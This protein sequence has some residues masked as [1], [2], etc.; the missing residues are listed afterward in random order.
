MKIAI[1]GC[2]VA[3]PTLAYWLSRA[4][5][6][7]VLIEDAPQLRTGGYN[8][9]FWGIG[10]DIADQMGLIPR[11]RTSATRSARCVSSTRADANHPDLTQM[12]SGGDVTLSAYRYIEGLGCRYQPRMVTAFHSAMALSR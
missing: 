1:H 5:H 3:G 7:P 8:I 11:L 2:G 6:E 10:Y 12:S 9:D 4:G